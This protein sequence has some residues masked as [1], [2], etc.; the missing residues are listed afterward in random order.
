MPRLDR[1]MGFPTS[2][3]Y[4]LAF[5]TRNTKLGF[6]EICILKSIGFPKAEVNTSLIDDK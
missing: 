5:H 4:L 2:V 1:G 6:W 3:S